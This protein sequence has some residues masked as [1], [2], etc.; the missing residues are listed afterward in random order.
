MLEQILL[1]YLL[2]LIPYWLF[3]SSSPTVETAVYK[4]FVDT[5][6]QNVG[7]LDG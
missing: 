5:E 2:F 3:N 1:P 4:I 6:M 7:M